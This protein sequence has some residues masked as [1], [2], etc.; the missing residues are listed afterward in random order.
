[1]YTKGIK[2]FEMNWSLHL[3]SAFLI[4]EMTTRHSLYQ[5]H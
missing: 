3:H 2:Y 5:T 4:I 1:M